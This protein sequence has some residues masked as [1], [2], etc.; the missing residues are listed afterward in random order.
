MQW[1]GDGGR[2][3]GEGSQKS[4]VKSE[5]WGRKGRRVKCGLW[6]GISSFP[7]A[8]GRW[9]RASVGAV[10]GGRFAGRAGR[11]R[12]WVGRAGVGVGACDGKIPFS[13]K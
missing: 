11:G 13:Q 1:S 7:W 5:K 3:C 12:A 6:A 10:G 8:D 4:E 9:R 2:H